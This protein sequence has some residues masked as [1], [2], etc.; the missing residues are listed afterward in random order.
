MDE[1]VTN[2][3]YQLAYYYLEIILLKIILKIFTL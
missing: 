3:T 2:E 1:A